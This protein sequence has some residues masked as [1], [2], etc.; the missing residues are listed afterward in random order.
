MKPVLYHLSFIFYHLSDTVN[1]AEHLGRGVA[2]EGFLG[3]P[4]GC[5]KGSLGGFQRASLEPFC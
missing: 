1:R 4:Q 5:L 2:G 3:E